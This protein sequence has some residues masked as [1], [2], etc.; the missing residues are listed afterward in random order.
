VV[1]TQVKPGDPARQGII[2]LASYPRSG[3]TWTRHFINNLFSVLEGNGDT[4]RD[5]DALGEFTIWDIPARRFEA[6]IGKPLGDAS[7]AEIAHAR[8]QVQRRI[9]GDANGPVL[10]KTHNALMLDEGAATINLAVTA[11]AIYIVRNPLDVAIS[12]ASHFDLSLDAAIETMAQAGADTGLTGKAAYEVYGSWSENVS[13]WTQK[14]HPAMYVMRY[15]DMLETPQDVFAGLARHLLIEAADADVARAIALSSFANA[16]AQERAKGGYVE[17]P[18]QSK[19]FFREGRAGQWRE[20]L[21]ADQVT[22]IVA[23]H[24]GQMS[25]FGYVP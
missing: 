9:A 5:I 14:P 6:V 19:A 13:S 21:S 8:G 1:Q 7:R 15:E 11:G 23:A 16:Q 18:K 12:F 25:R 17:R 3:N 10:V 4:P 20:V 24:R 2:W 22:R